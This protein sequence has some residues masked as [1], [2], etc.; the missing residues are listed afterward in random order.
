MKTNRPL[1]ILVTLLGCLPAIAQDVSPVAVFQQ[2]VVD[3]QRSPTDETL[4]KVINQA[5][6]LEQLPP[7]PEEARKHF[8]RAGAVFSEAKTPEAYTQ[9][10]AEYLQ[11]IQLA[12]WVAD[13]HYN[14]AVVREAAGDFPSALK[15]LK[16]YLLF[17]LPGDESRKAQDKVYVLEVKAEAAAKKLAEEQRQAAAVAAG[18][19]L[20]EEKLQQNRQALAVLKALTNGAN[21]GQHHSGRVSYLDPRYDSNSSPYITLSEW[22]G[23][24][25]WRFGDLTVRYFFTE[26]KVYLGYVYGNGQASP[27]RDPK[28]LSDAGAFLY[29]GTPNGSRIADISWESIDG[30]VPGNTPLE[31]RRKTRVWANVYEANGDFYSSGARPPGQ[32]PIDP[33]ARYAYVWFK[34]Q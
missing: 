19:R 17:K 20:R 25:W 23:P 14:L 21:Y 6:A 1:F 16:Q 4:A 24:V 7:V 15:S 30:M 31:A 27:N 2:A 28:N 9:A 3:Y 18:K 5:A 22:T 13:F 8:V 26:D 32:T 34:R 12:P 29:V 33:N 10:A 11:A